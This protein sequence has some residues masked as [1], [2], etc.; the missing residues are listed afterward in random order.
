MH[1]LHLYFKPTWV[2]IEQ[3][4]KILTKC[5]FLLEFFSN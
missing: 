2:T 4:R 5:I 3:S 1:I